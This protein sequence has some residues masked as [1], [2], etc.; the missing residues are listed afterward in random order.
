MVIEKIYVM[1][2][3]WFELVV[4]DNSSHRSTD[5]L[6]TTVTFEGFVYSINFVSRE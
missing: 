5:Y 6:A 2:V 3:M 1:F 4:D